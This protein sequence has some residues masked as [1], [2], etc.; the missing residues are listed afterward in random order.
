MILI[1]SHYTK[2]RGVT[3]FLIQHL[4]NKKLPFL[5]LKHP[6]YFEDRRVSE[7]VSINTDGEQ[8][9]LLTIKKSKISIVSMIQDFFINLF[10]SV[11]MGKKVR[12]V[13][14]FGSFNMVPF[15][16][17]NWLYKRNLYFWGCDYS[18]ERFKSKVLNKVY[19]WF[20]TLACKHSTLIIQPTIRQQLVREEKHGLDIRKSLIIPNGIE[21]FERLGMSKK[22]KEIA[23][24]YIGSI[25][26]QHGV[27]EFVRY[28]YSENKIPF[29]LFIFGSGED[30][31]ALVNL[32]NEKSLSDFVTYFGSKNAEEIK[33]FIKSYEDRFFGI[34]PYDKTFADHVYYGDSIKIKEYLSCGMPYITSEVTYLN[35]D[36]KEFGFVYSDYMELLD[37]FNKKISSFTFDDENR[38]KV[39]KNYVWYHLLDNFLLKA[40]I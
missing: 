32:I 13:I 11:K 14:G 19:F 10:V 1:V 36:I 9:I 8:K 24:I 12:K 40:N 15:I 20:E 30:E 5:Y 39:L 6:F 3:D 16:V 34:A 28:F 2:N 31:L 26:K 22:T 27:T 35:S 38:T 29:K 18:V 4:E 33:S 21:S 7:L 37:F 25:T 23:L 17:T